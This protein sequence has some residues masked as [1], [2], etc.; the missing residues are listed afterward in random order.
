MQDP[1]T[2]D[3][4]VSPRLPGRNEGSADEPPREPVPPA[5]EFS[6]PA[7]KRPDASV[8]PATLATAPLVDPN[9]DVEVAKVSPPVAASATIATNDA[10]TS[11]RLPIESTIPDP[12]LPDTLPATNV[13]GG[14][15]ASTDVLPR[16]NATTSFERW[17]G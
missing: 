17:S 11:M 12:G 9:I 3:L 8:N 14:P 5:P 1:A 4:A 7:I 2:G 6:E 13:G 10:G 16:T 15:L